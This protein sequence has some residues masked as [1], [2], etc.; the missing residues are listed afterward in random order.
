[1]NLWKSGDS[2]R[3]TRLWMLASQAAITEEICAS[4]PGLFC[5]CSEIDHLVQLRSSRPAMSQRTS[6]QATS[7]S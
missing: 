3:I 2:M 1:M 7:L 5:A 4:E 6:I